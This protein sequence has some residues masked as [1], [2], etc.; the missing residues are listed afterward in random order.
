MPRPS[1]IFDASGP[2]ATVTLDR[3]EC[4]N[5]VDGPTATRLREVFEPAGR[6]P[7]HGHQRLEPSSGQR[8]GHREKIGLG[9][10][11][12]CHHD[13]LPRVRPEPLAAAIQ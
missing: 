3:P 7:A 4:R 6:W 13:L 9:R 2:V 1:V 5:A 10:G 8:L 12:H 11:S